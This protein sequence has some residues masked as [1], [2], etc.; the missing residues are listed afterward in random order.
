MSNHHGYLSNSVKII[1]IPVISIVQQRWPVQ[2][3]IRQGNSKYIRIYRWIWW[4]FYWIYGCSLISLCLRTAVHVE[5]T[6]S[7]ISMSDGRIIGM[8]APRGETQPTEAYLLR[9]VSFALSDLICE[10]LPICTR[11][12]QCAQGGPTIRPFARAVY[13]GGED[14]IWLYQLREKHRWEVVRRARRNYPDLSFSLVDPN[15]F[16]EFLRTYDFKERRRNVIGFARWRV[17][18]WYLRTIWYV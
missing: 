13:Y 5:L 2:V 18:C 10:K 12:K 8:V 1:F 15:L 7:M 6:K 11:A 3:K 9:F 16:I 17:S 4:T 14:S